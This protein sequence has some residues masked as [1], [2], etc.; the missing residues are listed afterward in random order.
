MKKAHFWSAVGLALILGLLGFL[1]GGIFPLP[2]P[3]TT[4]K[5]REV[6]A[7]LGILISVLIFAPLSSWVVRT[8][9]KL[10]A[11]AMAR[12]AAEITNH[13]TS[14]RPVSPETIAQLVAQEG[15]V[16]D[17]S[18]IIDGRVL[19]VA[20][21]GFLSG[22]LLLPD[23]VLKELQQV[24]D[25][26]DALKRSRG[27]RGFEIVGELRKVKGVKL[28]VW[29]ESSADIPLGREVDDKLITLARAVKGKILT[30]DYNLSQVA[31]LRGIRVLNLNELAN[32]LKT[33]PVPGEKLTVKILHGGKDKDQG[34]GYTLDGVMVVVKDAAALIG[35][36]IDAEVTKILQG[37]SGRMIFGK[38]VD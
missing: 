10:A 35:K 28:Q 13:L 4:T 30:C 37:S 19:E 36:E 9:T 38:K 7:L 31:K 5:T 24:A 23:F 1:L 27:R 11:D 8:T 20:K 2:T 33:L 14:R 3:F 22:L 25:S 12:I 32:T 15:V 18:V 21:T 29:E 6:Y 17:T 34:V 26:G 16:L